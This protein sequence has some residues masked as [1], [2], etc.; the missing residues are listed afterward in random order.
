MLKLPVVTSSLVL[1]VVVV[2]LGLAKWQWQ[3]AEQKQQRL[4]NID[5]MQQKGLLSWSGVAL[6]PETLDKTGLRLKLQGRVQSKEYWLLDNRTLNGQPGYDLLAIFYPTGSA[7]GL[8]VNFGWVEQG[9]S[10]NK[11]PQIPLPEQQISITVQ[12]KQGDLAGFYLPGAE[13]AGTGWPKLIQ[14]IDIHQQA[15]QSQVQL[16]DF[17]AYALDSDS[18]AQP[19][20]QPVIMP[21]EKH[22]AYALQWLLISLSAVVVFVFA[23]R[24]QYQKDLHSGHKKKE[25]SN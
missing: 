3:R 12:L 9:L 7:L 10:R 22:L 15:Q 2:C 20:Y 4:D 1:I 17:M 6:L 14:F 16:V 23:L 19:H 13:L 25:T 21:P 5:A 8:L 18:F 24:N 11:L